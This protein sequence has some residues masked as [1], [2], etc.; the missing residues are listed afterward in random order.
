M[1]QL[2]NPTLNVKSG[3]VWNMYLKHPM[4]LRYCVTSTGGA[5]LFLDRLSFGS[6][7][8]THPLHPSMPALSSSFLA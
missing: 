4:M 2:K 8:V 3:H 1:N 5:V 6:M 7:G